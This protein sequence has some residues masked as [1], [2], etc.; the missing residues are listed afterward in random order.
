MNTLVVR[1]EPTVFVVDQDPAI[2]RVLKPIVALREGRMQCCRS[3]EDLLAACDPTQPGCI[4]V[5]PGPPGPGWLQ[6]FE[7]LAG[8]E[9][10]LPV[11]VLSSHCSVPA[12]VQAMQAGALDF[13]LKPCSSQH[14]SSALEDALRWD[15]QNRRLLLQASKIRRRLGE[16]N[17]GE[18][19]VLACLVRGL[20]NHQIAQELQVSV[21]AVEARRAKLMRKL[22]ARSLAELV[23]L[24]AIARFVRKSGYTGIQRVRDDCRERAFGLR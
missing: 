12:V 18:S 22:H 21:R 16:L 14:L 9:V 17:T 6:L 10:P 19:D 3:A 24:A 1:D 7:R 13:L 2:A 5:D 8:E 15:S 11:V 23:H 20:A 4:F